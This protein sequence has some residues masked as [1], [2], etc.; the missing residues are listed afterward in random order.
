MIG[1][2]ES[3]LVYLKKDSKVGVCITPS[4]EIPVAALEEMLSNEST[5]S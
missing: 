4:V 1:V 5:S 2:Y 3:R